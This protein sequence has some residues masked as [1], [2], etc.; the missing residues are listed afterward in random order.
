MSNPNKGPDMTLLSFAIDSKLCR[1]VL[2]S[3]SERTT[4][5]RT[6]MPSNERFVQQRKPGRPV[7][8]ELTEQTRQTI[9][10]HL[11]VSS[12]TGSLG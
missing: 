4:L 3:P 1:G 5:P 7:Q 6:S 2:L 8:F 11:E 10:E 9:D 12:G